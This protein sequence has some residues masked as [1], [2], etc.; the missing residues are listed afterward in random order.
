MNSTAPIAACVLSLTITLAAQQSDPPAA[1]FTDPAVAARED[2]GFLLQGEYAKPDIGLQIIAL[3]G[4]RFRLVRYP[5]G[6]PGLG[7]S[8]TGRQATEVDGATAGAAIADG[9][10][11]ITRQSPTLDAA[12]PDGAIVLFDGSAAALQNWQPGARVDA[13]GHLMAGATSLQGFGDA[14]VHVEFLLPYQPFARG[15]RRGNSGLYVQGRYETQM[16]DSFGLEGRHDECGGIY[17]VR[18]PDLNMCL[19]PLTWQSYD[20][21]FRAARFDEAGRKTENARMTVRL[22]GVVVHDDV[23]VPAQTA[24]SPLAEGDS[25]GPVHLQDHG[26]PVVYRRVWVLPR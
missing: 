10:Q 8:R 2:P 18:A 19:P 24:A 11:K 13:R 17:S 23:E 12:A 1:I 7:W 22:N 4:D 15:Q 26:D 14:L 16:L 20:V 6:L 25:P 21:E 3:G 5:G 9:F